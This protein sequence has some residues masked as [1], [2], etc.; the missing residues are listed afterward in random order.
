MNQIRAQIDHAMTW[1]KWGTGVALCLMAA[2]YLLEFLGVRVYGL[3]A[4]ERAIYI[5]GFWWLVR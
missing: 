3:P 4:P 5:A 2:V 1:V